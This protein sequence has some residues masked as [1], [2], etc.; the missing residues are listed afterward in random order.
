[1]KTKLIAVMIFILILA[2]ACAT[3]VQVPQ[4]AEKT[5]AQ[6]PVKPAVSV[7]PVVPVQKN[8]PSDIKDLLAK[9]ETRAKSASYLYQGPETGTNLYQFY[10]KGDKIRYIPSRS[11]KSLDR[12]DSFDS[13]FIDKAAKTARQY[14]V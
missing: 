8:I 5:P 12:Q 7:Q 11:L 9:A 6:A 10:V 2:S 1:M 4:P 14:C 3:Q 13:I